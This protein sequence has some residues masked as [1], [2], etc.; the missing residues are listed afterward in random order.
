VLRKRGSMIWKSVF[1]SIFLLSILTLVGCGDGEPVAADK[2]LNAAER[3]W[4]QFIPVKGTV[5]SYEIPL[6]LENTQQFIDWYND[7]DL[8]VAQRALRDGALEP[9]VAPCCDEY[10]MSTCCCEC[11]LSR[12]IWGLSAYLITEKGYTE[13]QLQEAILQWVHFI[14][15]DYYVASAL[16]EEGESPRVFGLSTQS[17]CFTDRC[18]LPFY[19]KTEYLHLGGCGG[20]DDLVQVGTD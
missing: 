17:S 4:A 13:G 10:P 3:I 8:T 5:T 6:S 15:P 14:R 20:M 16:E 12:S 11:N 19:S 1:L 18:E 9:L 2:T 7:I